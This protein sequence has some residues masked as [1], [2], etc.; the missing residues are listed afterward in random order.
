MT[1]IIRSG[2]FVSLTYR[3][4][5]QDGQVLE[6]NDLP[7]SYVHGDERALIGGLDQAVLGHQAGDEVEVLVPPE[8]GF[9]FHDPTLTFTDAIENVPP[10]I[11]RIGAEVAMQNEAG[12]MLMFH[13]TQIQ[14]GQ[15]T[16][17]ANHPFAGK[18]LRVVARI[19]E[20]RNPTDADRQALAMDPNWH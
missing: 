16:V 15:L 17:D 12:D 4:F 11:C 7:V 10:E 2:K 8:E 6:H 9:G 19:L 18:T 14:D 1:D 13:V 3:I 5:D 20:V